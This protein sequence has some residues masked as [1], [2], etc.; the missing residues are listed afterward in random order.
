MSREGIGDNAE[1]ALRPSWSGAYAVCRPL[2][3]PLPTSNIRS[4][5][6][7]LVTAEVSALACLVLAAL[8]LVGPSCAARSRSLP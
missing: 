5:E 1:M 7:F 3:G 8:L 4:A 6:H 2:Y